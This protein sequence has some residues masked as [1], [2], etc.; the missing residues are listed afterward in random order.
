MY[1]KAEPTATGSPYNLFQTN[2]GPSTKSFGITPDPNHPGTVSMDQTQYPKPYP[3]PHPK[4]PAKKNNE[5]QTH[6]DNPPHP[7]SRQ[8][9]SEQAVL[10]QQLN[11]YYNTG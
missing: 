2:R 5:S 9:F 1:K 7:Q 3:K 8:S 6:L 11:E 4:T 10:N